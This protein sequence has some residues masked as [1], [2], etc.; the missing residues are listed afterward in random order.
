MAETLGSER[1]KDMKQRKVV[2][3]LLLLFS[4]FTVAREHRNHPLPDSV[5]VLNQSIDVQWLDKDGTQY[6]WVQEF[7]WADGSLHTLYHWRD[8][9]HRRRVV[10]LADTTLHRLLTP[11]AKES[12]LPLKGRV[13]LSDLRLDNRAPGCLLFSYNSKSLQF[14][15]RTGRVSE[16]ILLPDQRKRGMRWTRSESWR[17]FSSDSAYCVYTQD[18]NLW[19]ARTKRDAKG[20]LYLCDSVQLSHDAVH[21]YSFSVSGNNMRM[22]KRGDYALPNGCWMGN[23][24]HFILLREDQRRVGT[25]TLVN[26]L[27]QPRPTSETYHF[28]MPGDSIVPRFEVWM[29]DA[30]RAELYPVDVSAYTDQLLDVPR[31]GRFTVVGDAAYLVRKSR[32]QDSTDLLRIRPGDR[33]ATLLIRESTKPHLNEQL[34]GFHVLNGGKDILW[35]AERG[36]RGQWW[37]Y[38]EA[39]HLRNA[40][41]PPD[42]VAGH[43]VR[44]DTL[45]R[46]LIL[47]G[48]GR[49]GGS[50]A[51]YSYY[52]KVGWNGRGLRLLTPGDGNHSISLSCGHE[53]RY[54][55]DTYSRVDM[56]PI[57]RLRDMRGRVIDTLCT[58]DV[59]ALLASGW[60]YPQQFTLRAS[61][62]STL[63]HGVVYT[64]WDMQP[65]DTLPIISN[66]Y[67]GPHTD[68]LPLSFTLDDNGNQT[69]A[70]DGFVVL[71]FS[72]RGSNPWRGRRFYSYGYGNLRDYALADDHAAI[73]QVARLVPQAD[74]TR[75]GIWGHSGGGF[76][77]AAALLSNPNFYKVGVSASGNHDNNIYTKW[78]G[79]TFHGRGRIPTNIELASRLKGNLLL[80]H[81]DMDN[82]VH[83]ANTMRLAHA[84]ICA[85]KRFDMLIIPGAD[86]ALGDTY[87]LNT[88][89]AYL[90]EHL[91]GERIGVDLIEK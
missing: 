20:C 40:V 14:D 10:T 65:G 45:S 52:Y 87:F 36:D 54:I 84:L 12:Q 6:W 86:H 11:F 59:S 61:D 77:A 37:L 60:R 80:I 42:M 88:I 78:W 41:T 38:D 31:F 75:V 90:R 8:A 82:N 13:Y 74:T 62:D 47:A 48:Y 27:S 56:A 67:P 57:H 70:N 17:N 58:A 24:H 46:T 35:W 4:V 29:L 64:P 71:N 55:V 26:S 25:I 89:R 28:P 21:F 91:R 43:I 1:K 49:E 85:G 66:P 15:S 69:L 44:I 7:R 23:S 30:T 50:N 72:Y 76:M 63:I 22:P 68:L 73:C 81:G 39:G 19:M 2:T 34:F 51:A 3:G 83:P 32:Y 16:S 79:E 5:C 53:S 33:C 9:L 18:H